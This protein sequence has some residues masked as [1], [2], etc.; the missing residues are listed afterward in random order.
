MIRDFRQR[1]EA[2]PGIA[3][4][5]I[6]TVAKMSG[7]Y[8]DSVTPGYVEAMGMKILDGRDFR[9]SDANTEEHGPRKTTWRVFM[10]NKKFAD[11]Y[12]AGRNPIGYHLGM[13]GDPGTKT[14]IEIVG[15]FSDAKYMD[16]REEFQIQVLV[17][18]YQTGFPASMVA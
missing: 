16:M 9:D 2:S 7:P 4:V 1:A 6:G 15:V 17:P 13:G 8:F 10:I 5:G 14:D 11:T 18:L 12:F 3:K